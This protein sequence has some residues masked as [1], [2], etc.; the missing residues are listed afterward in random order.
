MVLS[1]VAKC[2]A[3][4]IAM[5]FL[6]LNAKELVATKTEVVQVMTALAAGSLTEAAMA[7]WIRE[8]LV[9]LTL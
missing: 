5:V 3:F 9:R 6:G 4:L 1:T 7:Q 2:T 8:R